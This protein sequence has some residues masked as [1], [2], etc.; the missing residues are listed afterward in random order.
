LLRALPINRSGPRWR[1]N[2]FTL[3]RG[4]Q[5]EFDELMSPRIA[6]GLPE[7]K[8]N[9]VAVLNLVVWAEASVAAL[10]PTTVVAASTEARSRALRIVFLFFC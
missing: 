4:S 9:D 8:P 5:A 1:R 3:R 6:F 2:T 7:K 10:A